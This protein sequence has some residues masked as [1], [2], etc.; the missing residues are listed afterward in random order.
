MSGKFKYFSIFYDNA[1]GQAEVR[2]CGKGKSTVVGGIPHKMTRPVY[3]DYV[4]SY[5]EH[6]V[7]SVLD[8]L[9]GPEKFGVFWNNGS[10]EGYIEAV[11]GLSGNYR[12]S[13][14]WPFSFASEHATREAAQA[15]L[16]ELFI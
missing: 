3:G 10:L 11:D 12:G 1:A 9:G 16:A 6:E 5:P 4:G 8:K 7:R 15:A 2:P 14:H 13:G